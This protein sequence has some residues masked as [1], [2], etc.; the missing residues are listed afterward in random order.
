MLTNL[1]AKSL[2]FFFISS[3]KFHASTK[4]QSGLSFILSLEIIGA[5]FIRLVLISTLFSRLY[6]IGYI[7]N[8]GDE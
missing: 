8:F 6:G 1:S 3:K 7:V 2:L 4:T 5:V